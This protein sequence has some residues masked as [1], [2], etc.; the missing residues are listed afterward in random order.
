MVTSTTL[1]AFQASNKLICGN[2]KKFFFQQVLAVHIAYIRIPD[3]THFYESM[4]C[5]TWYGMESDV[6]DQHN[7]DLLPLVLGIRWYWIIITALCD[8]NMYC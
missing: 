4:R 1:T 5:I 7:E 8:S 3:Y 2:I 6:H